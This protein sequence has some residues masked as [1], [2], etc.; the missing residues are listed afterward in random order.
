MIKNHEEF[1][2]LFASMRRKRELS[3]WSSTWYYAFSDR[4]TS[5]AK[6]RKFEKQWP[7]RPLAAISEAALGLL[8]GASEIGAGWISLYIFRKAW[9]KNTWKKSMGRQGCKTRR[10]EVQLIGSIPMYPLM[11]YLFTE[12]KCCGKEQNHQNMEAFAEYLYRTLAGN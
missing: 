10:L 8:T 6:R 5:Y 12:P 7:I 3:E 9:S 4:T 11:N 2:Y 1:P